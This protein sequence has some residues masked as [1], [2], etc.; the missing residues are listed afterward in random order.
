MYRDDEKN[1]SGLTTGVEKGFSEAFLFIFSVILHLSHSLKE[2]H[3]A[4]L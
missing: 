1:N 4:R 2:E 3:G